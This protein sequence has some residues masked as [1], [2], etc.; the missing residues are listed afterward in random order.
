MPCTFMLCALEINI[1]GRFKQKHL[2][3]CPLITKTWYFHYNSALGKQPWQ[4]DDYHEGLPPIKA[5]D[6]LIIW[7]CEITWQTKTISP[8]PVS[9]DAKLGRMLGYPPISLLDPL[10]TWSC[11]IMEK[12]QN[13]SSLP[14]CLWSPN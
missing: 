14:Q 8:L 13:I 1:S 9:M 3:S 5:H 2:E 12:T 4:C 7:S 10:V 11:K 6:P